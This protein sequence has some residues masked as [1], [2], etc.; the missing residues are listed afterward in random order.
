MTPSSSAELAERFLA[1]PRPREPLL[2]F[3]GSP[4]EPYLEGVA[5]VFFQ[6]SMR[7]PVVV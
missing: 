1:L 7:Q 2:K 5:K 3:T 6:R 4:V